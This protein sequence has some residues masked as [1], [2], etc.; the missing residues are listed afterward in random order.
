M[1]LNNDLNININSLLNVLKLKKKYIEKLKNN[2]SL[3]NKVKKSNYKNLS[4]FLNQQKITK[5][6]IIV[7]YVI[8]IYFLKKNIMFHVSDFEGKLISFFSSGS[9]KFKGKA[10]KSKFAVFKHFYNFLLSQLK[11]LR[12][13][14]IAV[15]LHNV[16][17]N[18]T[19]MIHK[20]KRKFFIVA[21]KN[22]ISFPHNGCRKP[23]LR[24]KKFRTKR[25]K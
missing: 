21:V 14:P 13:K 23:K 2:I 1:T 10:K 15:H 5:R 24:R 20:L 11:F 4:S 18:K 12:G 17:S 3:L 9:F 25:R 7:L 6:N 16:D 22:F 19:W 8:S